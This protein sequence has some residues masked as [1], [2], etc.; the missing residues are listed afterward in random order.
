MMYWEEAEVQKF[1]SILAEGFD[2]L[3]Q[4][5]PTHLPVIYAVKPGIQP[6]AHRYHH[7]SRVIRHK[8][9]YLKIISCMDYDFS[10]FDRVWM[11]YYGVLARAKLMD[12]EVRRFM[13]DMLFASLA[14]IYNVTRSVSE[15]PLKSIFIIPPQLIT[16]II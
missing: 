16:Y 8:P 1:L 15:T 11:S 3:E 7:T 2:E 4:I 9:P 6:A 14:R 12:R 5:I 10:A 13:A